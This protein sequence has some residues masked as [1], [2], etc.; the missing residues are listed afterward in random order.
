MHYDHFALIELTMC[1]FMINFHILMLIEIQMKTTKIFIENGQSILFTG[2]NTPIHDVTWV[3]LSKQC[4][5][6]SLYTCH[7]HDCLPTHSFLV[8]VDGK[9]RFP[10][11]LQMI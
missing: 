4:V 2:Q 10:N 11:L 3:S 6:K 9:N 8:I 5:I 1:L 7:S